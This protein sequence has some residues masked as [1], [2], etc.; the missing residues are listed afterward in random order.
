MPRI[1]DIIE[2]RAGL[3]EE[4][5]GILN[6]ADAESRDLTAEERQEYD[7]QEERCTELEGDIRRHERQQ[8]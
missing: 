1:G 5:R 8:H 2:E 6:K 7:R 3:V 4:M